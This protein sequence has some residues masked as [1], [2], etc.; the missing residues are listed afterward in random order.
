[1]M[2][3]KQVCIAILDIILRELLFKRFYA[4]FLSAIII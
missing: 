1:M 3:S 4:F 2:I